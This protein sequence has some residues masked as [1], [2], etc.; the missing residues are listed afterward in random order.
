MDQPLSTASDNSARVLVIDDEETVRE[1]IADILELEGIDVFLAENGAEGVALFQQEQ[2]AVQLIILD[3]HMPGLSGAET[4]RQLRQINPNVPILLSS[5]Y[6]E[7]ETRHL[8][9]EEHVDFLQKPFTMNT[10]IQQ[11]QAYF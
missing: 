2:S 4:L 6:S 9:A 3:V 7:V 1:A 11:V 10:L 8:F 5:G